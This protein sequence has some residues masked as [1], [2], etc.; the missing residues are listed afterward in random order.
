MG[1]GMGGGYGQGG[2]GQ[3]KPPDFTGEKRGNMLT[4]MTIKPKVELGKVEKCK[5]GCEMNF[6]TCYR[7]KTDRIKCY[8]EQKACIGK[9][10]GQG[11]QGMPGAGQGMGMG[12]GMG[13]Y[14]MGMGGYGMGM[15]GYY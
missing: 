2:Q 4:P 6:T 15:G 1:M 8:E 3:S 14:G 7:E 9:C 5:I 12:M 11:Q 13:G 10:T